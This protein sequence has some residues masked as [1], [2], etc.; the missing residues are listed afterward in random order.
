MLHLWPLCQQRCFAETRTTQLQ[1]PSA[2][3]LHRTALMEL[4]S[5]DFCACWHKP[6]A[7]DLSLPVAS[8]QSGAWLLMRKLGAECPVILLRRSLCWCFFCCKVDFA[9]LFWWFGWPHV[10]R[11]LIFSQKKS[12]QM[13][14]TE[15]TRVVTNTNVSLIHS[16]I[17]YSIWASHLYS[18]PSVLYVPFSLSLSWLK[19][20]KMDGWSSYLQ[21]RVQSRRFPLLI[22]RLVLLTRSS[23]GSF[24]LLQW[25]T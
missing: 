12:P 20:C 22:A 5:W 14:A 3:E 11:T 24:V 23:K 9:Y 15:Y 1:W 17:T 10:S 8:H 13:L 21:E 19:L 6:L 18:A 7:S 25:V 4:P 16:W 2:C